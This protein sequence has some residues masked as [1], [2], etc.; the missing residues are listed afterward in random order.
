MYEIGQ[1]VDVNTKDFNDFF[2]I[3]EKIG[4]LFCEMEEISKNI[5]QLFA[6]I[7]KI[8]QK[9]TSNQLEISET[10]EKI[11][12]LSESLSLLEEQSKRKKE[13]IVNETQ[14]FFVKG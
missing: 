10:I 13:E 9:T 11:K 4:K 1:C 5:R 12:V 2:G 8:I 14:K 3:V 6:D 7:I